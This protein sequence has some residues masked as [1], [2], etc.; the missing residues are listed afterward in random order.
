MTVSNL[1]EAKHCGMLNDLCC[2]AAIV[3]EMIYQ[4]KEVKRRCL[5]PVVETSRVI[6]DGVDQK[7]NSREKRKV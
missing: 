3:N 7:S 4:G 2:R 1:V 5:L 6:D